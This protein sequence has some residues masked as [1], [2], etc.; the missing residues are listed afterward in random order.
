TERTFH[1]RTVLD[2][3]VHIDGNLSVQAGIVLLRLGE[4]RE[5]DGEVARGHL[6][7]TGCGIYSLARKEDRDVK[8]LNAERTGL[9][10]GVDDDSRD[11]L[12]FMTEATER[13]VG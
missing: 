5:V 10:G 1:R 8:L 2:E 3:P 4:Q 6:T 11:P 13:G 7:T 9:W 12:M